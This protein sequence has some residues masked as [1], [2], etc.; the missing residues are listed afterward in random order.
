MKIVILCIM[1][2]ACSGEHRA[3]KQESKYTNSPTMGDAAR[4]SGEKP[5]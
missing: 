5:F 1:F 2:S 4:A 3:I